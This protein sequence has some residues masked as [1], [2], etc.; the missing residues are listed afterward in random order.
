VAPSLKKQNDLKAEARTAYSGQVPT[1]HPN[2][3]TMSTRHHNQR[4]E[5]RLIRPL[6]ALNNFLQWSSGVIVLGIV[7]YFISRYAHG[8]HL[9][10]E[11]VIVSS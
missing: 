6:L 9:T 2:K 1:A 7:S 3:H 5:S 8:E 10:Y 11:E 4:D